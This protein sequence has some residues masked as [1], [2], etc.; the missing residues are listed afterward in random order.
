[1]K[2]LFFG[3]MSRYIAL[4]LFT[5]FTVWW[6]V[7]FFLGYKESLHN[8][9]FGALYGIMAM[10]GGVIG[11]EASKR[12]GGI[13]SL[14]GKAILFLALGLLAAEFG[15]IVFS[16]YNIILHIE[17]PYPSVADIGFFGN[18][19]LYTTGIF[20]LAKASGIQ[21]T[22]KKAYGKVS[23][24]IFPLIMLF[25]SYLFFLQGYEF[26]WSDPI[27]IFLDFSYP[28]GQA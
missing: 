18:I 6:I 24:I 26:D 16:Y 23:I 21:I 4:L 8:Y 9:I 5:T 20:L 1:M 25:L 2:R 27:L 14:M 12:W 22:L 7:I 19:P 11:I 15:Q 28:L 10:Y 13:H 17:I 3:E